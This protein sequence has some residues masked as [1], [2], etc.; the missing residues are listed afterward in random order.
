MDKFGSNIE[1]GDIV[2]GASYLPNLLIL[3]KTY[4]IERTMSGIEMVFIE[5]PNT[6]KR[7]R[8]FQEKVIKLGKYDASR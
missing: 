2:I 6:R 1:I 7:Y 8:F 4:N 3:G 5:N